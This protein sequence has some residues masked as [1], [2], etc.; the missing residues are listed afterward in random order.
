VPRAC[1][2]H[3]FAIGI[4]EEAIRI[5]V[6]KRERKRPCSIEFNV[7]PGFIEEFRRQNRKE[8]AD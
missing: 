3:Q 4:V 8:I 1:G 5:F 7:D 6:T 2:V